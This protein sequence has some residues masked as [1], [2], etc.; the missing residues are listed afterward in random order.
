M[1][2]NQLQYA[3]YGLLA[4]AIFAVVVWQGWNNAVFFH[5]PAEVQA[6]PASFLGRR[7]RVGGLV[8]PRSVSWDPQQV[9]LRFVVTD[10]QQELRVHFVGARPDLFREGQGVVAEGR[11]QADGT[12]RAERLLVK[13]SEEYRADETW[14][15]DKKLLY[16]SLLSK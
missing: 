3:I 12:L 2:K 15:A 14:H 16:K 4:L 5:T 10:G 9:L 6:E 8:R 7:L 13:H 11:L 1:S